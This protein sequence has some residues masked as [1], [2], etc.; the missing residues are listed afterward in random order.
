MWLTREQVLVIIGP[1]AFCCLTFFAS[2]GMRFQR[3]LASSLSA[4]NVFHLAA[5]RGHTQTA[6][7]G[8]CSQL[9]VVDVAQEV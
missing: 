8:P 3:N 2:T 7:Q 5:Y 4:K 1:C 6:A 9:L